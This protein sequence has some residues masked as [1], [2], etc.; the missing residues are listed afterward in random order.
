MELPD[1]GIKPLLQQLYDI[2]HNCLAT[3]SPYEIPN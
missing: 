2:D 3:I 1:R